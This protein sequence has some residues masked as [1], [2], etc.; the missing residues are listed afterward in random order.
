[1][2]KTFK[3]S[4]LMTQLSNTIKSEKKSTGQSDDCT[5]G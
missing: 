2:G 1:M 3:I 4:Q 5:T